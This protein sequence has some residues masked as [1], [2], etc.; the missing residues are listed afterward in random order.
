MHLV[1]AIY[2]AGTAGSEL[3]D[4]SL[5]GLRSECFC[6]MLDT[7]CRVVPDKYR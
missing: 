3:C 5:Y 1:N 6:T 4:A 7:F 2:T